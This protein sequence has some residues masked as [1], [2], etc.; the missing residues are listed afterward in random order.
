MKSKNL[1]SPLGYKRRKGLDNELGKIIFS[2]NI[3]ILDSNY[4][5]NLPSKALYT[6]MNIHPALPKFLFA[7]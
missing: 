3:G 2:T 7:N 5:D 6:M 4:V 1:N